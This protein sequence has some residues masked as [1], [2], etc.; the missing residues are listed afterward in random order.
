MKKLL[1]AFVFVLAISAFTA[2]NG[3]T[4]S[5]SSQGGN[6]YGSDNVI[7]LPEDKFN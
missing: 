3:K 1:F 7:E 2:C 4:D 5:S 6:A